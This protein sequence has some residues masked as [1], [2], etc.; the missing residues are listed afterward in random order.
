MRYVDAD[1][2]N[3][4]QPMTTATATTTETDQTMTTTTTDTAHMCADC[5]DALATTATVTDMACVDASNRFSSY[6]EGGCERASQTCADYVWTVTTATTTTTDA[7]LLADYGSTDPRFIAAVERERRADD[8]LVAAMAS[9]NRDT[10]LSA[11][12]RADIVQALASMNRRN[13]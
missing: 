13:R 6:C 3:Y 9:V 2:T 4:V 8:A 11:C 7:K 1:G 5:A 10:T 12:D